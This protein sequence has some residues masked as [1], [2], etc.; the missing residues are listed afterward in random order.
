[1]GCWATTRRSWRPA[2]STSPGPRSRGPAQ[3]V[4]LGQ[5]PGTSVEYNGLNYYLLAS[6]T[7][8]VTGKPFATALRESV[9]APLGVEG[10]FGVEPPRPPA[11]VGGMPVDECT[12][13][14]LERYN[15]PFDRVIGLPNSGLVVTAAGALALVHA[16]GEIPVDFLAAGTRAAAMSDQTSGLGGG[17]TSVRYEHCPWGLGPELRGDKSPHWVPADASPN[18]SG[19]T[20]PPDVWSGPIR[21]PTWPGRSSAVICWMACTA[22]PS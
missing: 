20:A 10:Y 5:P 4:P 7:E 21:G 15:T 22:A 1:V 16:F 3:Q 18:P 19:T 11:Y 13:T 17:F 2:P 14:P 9:L 12:G 6:V 8:R